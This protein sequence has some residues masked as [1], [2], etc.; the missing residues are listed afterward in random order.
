LL[1]TFMVILPKIGLIFFNLLLLSPNILQIVAN[2][3]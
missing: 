2:L 1:P 3:I